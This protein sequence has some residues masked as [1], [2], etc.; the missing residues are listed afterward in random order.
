VTAVRFRALTI[1]IALAA[2][3][4]ISSFFLTLL[5]LEYLLP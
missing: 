1:L 4:V 2:M 3:V 5:M